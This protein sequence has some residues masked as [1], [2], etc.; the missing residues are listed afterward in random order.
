MFFVLL[1]YATIVVV[2]LMHML[3]VYACAKKDNSIIDPWWGVGFALI[4]L[5]TFIAAGLYLPRH[6]LITAMTCIWAMR[7]SVHL[8]RRNRGKPE[9]ARYAKWREQWGDTVVWR[10]YLQVFMLQ[11]LFMLIIALPIIVVNTSTDPGLTRFDF[12]GFLIWLLGIGMEALADYQLNIYL[13]NPAHRGR[14]MQEGLWRYSR[15]PNYVGEML[16]WWGMWVIAVQVPYGLLALISPLTITLLLRFVS[17]VP[18]AEEQ[19][20]KLAEYAD[21]ARTTNIFIPWFKRK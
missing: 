18:L 12:V 7:I 16:I 19:M 14:I 3:F 17:G 5:V 8:L 1:G 10:S 11:G 15:H 9:D 21:Y 20:K 6:I 2:C 13:S 4:A